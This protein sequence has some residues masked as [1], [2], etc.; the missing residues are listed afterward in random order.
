M[1]DPPILSMM[2][3]RLLPSVQADGQKT[4]EHTMTC[5]GQYHGVMRSNV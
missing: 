2:G 3:Q 1:I 5:T 4:E